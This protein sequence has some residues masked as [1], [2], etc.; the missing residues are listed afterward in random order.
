MLLGEKTVLTTL[1]RANAETVR[2]WLNDARVNRY[3]LTG[4]VP[5]TPEQEIAFYDASDAAWAAGTAYRFE[6]HVSGD[7]RYIG[8]CGL[9]RVDLRHRDATIGIVIGD[10]ASQ[11]KGFGRDGHLP[12]EQ[13]AVDTRVVEPP[14]DGLRVGP[15]ERGQDRL[16]A[17]QHGGLPVPE[18][19]R[20]RAASGQGYRKRGG[21]RHDAAMAAM[22]P[23]RDGNRAYPCRNR[24]SDADSGPKSAETGESRDV[25]TSSKQSG[26]NVR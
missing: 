13:V 12:G 1:D 17:E 24:L 6:I 14:A 16:C 9:D 20:G 22:R 11:D 18:N 8:N 15:V 25:E 21:A 2:G 23:F 4:Q 3:L 19:D 5:V 26:S 7:G 10:L